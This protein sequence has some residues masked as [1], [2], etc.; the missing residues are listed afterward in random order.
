MQLVYTDG[1]ARAEQEHADIVRLCESGDY[2]RACAVLRAHIV[3]AGEALAK[4]L[5]KKQQ[6]TMSEA[7]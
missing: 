1:R 3:N 6:T 2:K 4:L 5:K 7:S